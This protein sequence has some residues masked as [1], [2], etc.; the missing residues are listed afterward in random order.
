ML[1]A[2][3]G[4]GCH[5]GGTRR[6]FGAEPEHQDYLENI[7]RYPCPSFGLLDLRTGI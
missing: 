6:T 2:L 5:R 3:A 7:G 1:P 4:Q